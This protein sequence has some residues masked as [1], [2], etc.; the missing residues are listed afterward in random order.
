M[1]S[2]SPHCLTFSSA[3]HQTV[4]LSFL[5]LAGLCSCSC[6]CSCSYSC[7]YSCSSASFLS[8]L[9]NEAEWTLDYRTDSVSSTCSCTYKS[10]LILATGT[11]VVIYRLRSSF[12]ISFLSGTFCS[13]SGE[14]SLLMLL[15]GVGDFFLT[16]ALKLCKGQLSI[17]N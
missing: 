17:T 12:L 8:C 2:R 11:S 5:F 15:S 1:Q 9:G 10:S 3:S 13:C 16:P 6:S 4:T 14:L 7:S